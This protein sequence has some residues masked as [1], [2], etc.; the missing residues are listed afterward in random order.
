MNKMQKLRNV[1]PLLVVII[2]SGFLIFFEY[3]YGFVIPDT[4]PDDQ[5]NQL[6]DFEK[7]TLLYDNSLDSSDDVEE[8]IMEG[9]GVVEFNEGWMEMQSPN[10]EFHHVFWC[11]QDFPSQFIAQWEVQNLNKEAGLTIVFFAAKGINGQDIFDNSLPSRNGVFTQ[12]TRG[13]INCY[14][15]SYHSNTPNEPLRE[16]ANLRKNNGFN[17]VQYGRAGLSRDSDDVHQI[18]LIKDDNHILMF[19]DSRE[20]INWVDDGSIDSSIL[21]SGKIGFRQ[22]K[23]T[24]FKYR[25]FKVYNLENGNEEELPTS[26]AIPSLPLVV[27]G[28]IALLGIT[29]IL[30]I[31]K[32]RSNKR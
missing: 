16:N 32:Y 25:N 8:W 10:Q 23:W 30:Y 14:H 22:M 3:Q 27:I 9:P 11:D 2:T 12:Y 17:L 26:L 31:L 24:Y 4:L 19:I 5:I 21:T 15:I 18:T 13:Q 28:L 20:I 29:I 1:V 6:S 7:G